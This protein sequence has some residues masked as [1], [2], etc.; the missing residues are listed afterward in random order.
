MK[1]VTDA[2]EAQWMQESQSLSINFCLYGMLYLA[3]N[4]SSSIMDIY[5]DTYEQ[6]KKFYLKS[7]IN[8]ARSLQKRKIDFVLLTNS[9]A[10]IQASLQ[11]LQYQHELTVEEVNFQ[12]Y[13]PDGLFYY[14][15]HFKLD[16]FR[17]FASLD[18]HSY[19][20]LIDL[21]I[22]A[23]NDLPT[24]FENLIKAKI[25]ICYDVS[26]QLI[27]AFSH[28]VILQDMQKL[29]PDICEGRWCGGELIAGTPSFFQTLSVE[30][31]G[32]YEQYLQKVDELFHKG[33]EM[34][35]SVALERIR[36]RGIYIADAGTLGIIGRFFSVPTIRHPQKSFKYFENCFLL[37]LPVDKDFLAK[38][39]PEQVEDR[40]QFLKHYKSYLSTVWMIRSWKKLQRLYRSFLS[41]K[42]KA[43]T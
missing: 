4:Q 40:H 28:R 12:L 7:A 25:P 37:H 8:L 35:T 18:Q 32:I 41:K 30:C 39:N 36:R 43:K 1:L 34:I 5:A 10:E 9:K 19:V 2:K 38:L 24:C 13:V 11:Q 21:D 29:A 6:K 23:V 20:G 33:D 14:S 27:P 15:T 16:V 22:V 3:E 31:N 42:A 26:D 17:Y